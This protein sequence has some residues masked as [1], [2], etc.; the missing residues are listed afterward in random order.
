MEHWQQFPPEGRD[1]EAQ[2]LRE[3]FAEEWSLAIADPTFGD[4]ED[5]DELAAAGQI[6]A[7]AYLQEAAS[8]QPRAI[9]QTV[10]GEIA[11]VKVRLICSTPRVACSTSRRPPSDRM[12]SRPNTVCN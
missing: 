2:E 11:G 7:A 1:I 3:V 9:E 12:E 4:D 8:L 5:A 10:Q 6:L